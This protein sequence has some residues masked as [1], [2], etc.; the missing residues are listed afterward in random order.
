[1]KFA[2][3]LVMAALLTVPAAMADDEMPD[4]FMNRLFA[5]YGDRAHWPKHYAPCDEFCEAP[6]AKLV[7]KLD[8]DPVCQCREGGG[9]Y[10]IVAGKLH[11]DATFEY[12]L[13]D[14]NNSRK[15]RQWI[16][17]LRPAGASW[18]IADVFERRLDGK[19]SLRK[20]LESGGSGMLL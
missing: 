17:I 2:C 11:P 1:M 10:I 9:R 16:V 14:A 18:K 6:L 12:T 4:A 20:R 7:K 19:P 8:Y 13:R 5:K 15:L 3:L